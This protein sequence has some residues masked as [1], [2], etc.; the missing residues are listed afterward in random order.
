MLLAKQI[1]NVLSTWCMVAQCYQACL[2]SLNT[3]F[4]VKLNSSPVL[5]H[6][7]TIKTGFNFQFYSQNKS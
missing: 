6:N 5:D 2:C 4:I 3:V 1:K 7:F